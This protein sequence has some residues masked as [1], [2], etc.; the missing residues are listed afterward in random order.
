MNLKFTSDEHR[1][2]FADLV[3][4]DKKT[5]AIYY[6]LGADDEL[7]DHPEEILVDGELRKEMLDADWQTKTSQKYFALALNLLYGINLPVSQPANLWNDTTDEVAEILYEAVDIYRGGGGYD[8][9][10]VRCD[11]LSF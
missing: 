3:T 4:G 7:R 5:D 8:E 11:W 2:Y 10:M 1:R 6:L 9:N